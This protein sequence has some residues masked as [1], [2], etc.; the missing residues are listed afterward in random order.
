M[1]C[2]CV[3]AEERETDRDLKRDREELERVPTFMWFC[4]HSSAQLLKIYLVGFNG[5]LISSV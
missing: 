1:Q 3:H 2:I 5:F 4:Y